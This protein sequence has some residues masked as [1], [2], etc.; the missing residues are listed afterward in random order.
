MSRGLQPVITGDKCKRPRI[1]ARGQKCSGQLEGICCTKRVYPQQ[2]YG[3][4][5]DFFRRQDFHAG[6]KEDFQFAQS[7]RKPSFIQEPFSLKSIEG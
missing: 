1:F 6:F 2:A 5:S 3:S 4:F 7:L